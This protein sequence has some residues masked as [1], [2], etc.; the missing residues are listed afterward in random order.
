MIM[1]DL[2]KEIQGLKTQINELSKKLNEL[3][4]STKYFGSSQTTLGKLSSDLTLQ[5]KGKVKI[6]FGSKFIDLIKDGKINSDSKIIYQSDSVGVKDGFYVIGNSIVL[7]IGNQEIDLSTEGNSFVSFQESQKSSSEQKYNALVNIGFLYKDMSQITEDSLQNGII[8][9]ESKKKLYIVS[10]GSLSEYSLELP[11]PFNKQFVINKNNTDKGSILIKGS[12]IENSIAFDSCFIYTENNQTYINSKEAL[13]IN[14]DGIN[15]A[16]I[17]KDYITFSNKVVSTTFQSASPYSVG[18]FGLYTLNGQ[19][20][21][22]VDNIVVRNG[23][24]SNSIPIYPEYWYVKNNIIKSAEPIIEED[25][26]VTYN[27]TLLFEN[28]FDVGDKLYVYSNRSYEEYNTLTLLP[29]EVKDVSGQV[30][31]TTLLESLNYDFLSY[32]PNKTIFLIGNSTGLILNIK[33]SDKGFDLVKSSGL[34]QTVV[35]RFGNLTELSLKGEING[36]LTSPIIGLGVYSD[37]AIFQNAQYSSD[38]TD[39]KYV[40]NNSSSFASTAFVHKVLPKNSIILYQGTTAP[41]GW[42]ICDGT[43]GRP[44]ITSTVSGTI[45]IIKTV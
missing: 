11:N 43:N 31:S 39:V 42:A 4:G 30:I 17:Q 44:T 45:Y 8:Y 23:I 2:S 14:L 32:L 19:S 27:I 36:Q 1:E 33:H 25:G 29:F 38:N 26:S 12:G 10:N 37:N 5:T 28:M 40:T 15:K 35:S 16:I 21:L 13:C 22:E 41:T 6:Q 18:G 9:V 24:E 20:V 34:N 7:K 3:T